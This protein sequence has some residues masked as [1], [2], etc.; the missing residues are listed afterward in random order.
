LAP[1]P[2]ALVHYVRLLTIA[3]SKPREYYE[4]EAVVGGWS[5]RQL[6]RQIASLACQRTR[7]A[8]A[9]ADQGET[10]LERALIRSL[11]RL[12]ARE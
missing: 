2:P 11:V 9:L 7:G 10:E 5:V 1:I 12:P 4:S 8:K 3:D 6:D